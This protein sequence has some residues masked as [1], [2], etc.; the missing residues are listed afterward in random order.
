[1]DPQNA[2]VYQISCPRLLPDT[3]LGG[4][5]AASPTNMNKTSPCA[6]LV[7]P[8]LL[9]RKPPLLLRKPPRLLRKPRLLLRKPHVALRKPRA[10]VRKPRAVQ[11]SASAPD[12]RQGY[13]R[14]V[15]STTAG[16]H[17]ALSQHNCVPT[18]HD[19]RSKSVWYLQ[20]IVLR[21]LPNSNA[22]RMKSF[23]PKHS[24]FLAVITCGAAS[25]AAWPILM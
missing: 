23:H 5:C 8:R 14:D 17:V 22:R 11:L 12:A 21:G 13:P 4:S 2:R 3:G 6:T 16:L 18:R 9:L 24:L 1:M 19:C 15:S 10:D 20:V 25:S 7:Q